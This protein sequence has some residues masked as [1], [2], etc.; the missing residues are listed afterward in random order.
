MDQSGN[1]MDLRE[2]VTFQ[3]VAQTLSFT[4][5]ADILGY[6]QSS[7]TAHIQLLEA[8]LGVPLFNRLGR[9]VSLT[10]AGVRLLSY[11]DRIIDLCAEAREVVASNLEISGTITISAPE[12]I[13]TYRLPAIMNSFREALP[14][15]RL[16]F[17]PMPS[18]ALYQALRDGT[19]DIAFLFE[20]QNK[21]PDL[22]LE[23]LSIEPLC[24]VAA[25]THRLAQSG[26]MTAQELQGESFLLTERG[27]PYRVDFE[28]SLHAFGVRS[29]STLEFSS[30]EAIK[31]CTIAGLGIAYLPQMAVADTLAAKKLVT[32]PWQPAQIY[33]QM[34]WHKNKWMS[35]AAHTFIN[36]CRKLYGLS[37]D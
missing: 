36:T 18:V 15:V 20:S 1:P 35:P 7:V 16:I 26:E 4:R 34:A 31:Q 8:D 10:E 6:T 25:P 23:M 5:S 9:R 3:T 32:L 21:L 37:G 33:L 2:L 17:Q 29:A 14:H 12:S 22:E 13:C 30:I 24:M 28:Q 11:A 19:I 27:C